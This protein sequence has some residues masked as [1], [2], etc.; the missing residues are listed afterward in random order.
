MSHNYQDHFFDLERDIIAPNRSPPLEKAE[1]VLTPRESPP[2]LVPVYPSSDS[3]DVEDAGEFR[4][5]RSRKSRKDPNQVDVAADAERYALASASQSE[6]EDEEEEEDLNEDDDEENEAGSASARMLVDNELVRHEALP[7]LNGVNAIAAA[8]LHA[9]NDKDGD[10][11]M[12]HSPQSSPKTNQVH[13]HATGY[14]V[15]SDFSY[16]RRDGCFTPPK[17][18]SCSTSCWNTNPPSREASLANHGLRLQLDTSQGHDDSLLTSPTLG[19]YTITPYDPDPDVVLPAMQLSP[20]PSSPASS[21][22]QKQTL[23]SLRTTLGGYHSSSTGF[24]G[25]SRVPTHHSPR[26]VDQFGPTLSFPPP[27]H[28]GMSP[29][30][31][32]P[33]NI[34]RTATVDSSI[35]TSSEYTP[36]SSAAASTPASSIFTPSPA[37]SSN[38][39][40]LTT[41]PE[42]ETSALHLQEMH[43]EIRQ[44]SKGPTTFSEQSPESDHDPLGKEA[45]NSIRS[46]ADGLYRCTYDGCNAA[47]FQTQYLLNSHMNVHSEMRTHFCPVAGCP[48]GPGGQGFKRKNEMIRHGLVH[49]SPGYICPFCADQQHRYP[50][51]DNLQRHVR[52]HHK[53]RDRDDPRLRQILNQRLESGNRTARRRIR[54]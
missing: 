22:Q 18:K 42:E 26:P 13:G 41:L 28:T 7:A 11:P 44:L 1:P 35:S 38:L 31:H 48:R 45:S 9:I 6:A 20:S 19:K 2:P 30:S 12:I 37:A 21:P 47:P 15:L 3:S 10:F 32:H 14:Q 24:P 5:S 54:T 40:P 25:L 29:P 16:T 46:L 27:T 8:A 4:P 23:P 53:D 33:R 52:A 39:Y 17:Q 49:T 36:A 34:Y 51:P 50:R 43:Q